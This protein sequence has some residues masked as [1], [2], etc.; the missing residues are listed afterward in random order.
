MS[1][2]NPPRLASW[3]LERFVSGPTRE[4]LI[5]DVAEQWRHGRS[6]GWY[7]RQVLTAIILSAAR[8]VW[9]HKLAAVRAVAICWVAISA[10]GIFTGALRESLFNN[11]LHTPW[12]S[13]IVRQAWVYYGLPFAIFTGIGFAVI[14][15]MISGL[16]RRH[17]AGMLLFCAMCQVLWS[18]PWGWETSRLLREGLWPFWDY[19]LALLFHGLLQFIGYPLCLLLGGASNRDEDALSLESR[20]SGR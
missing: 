4:S 12:R 15:W 1:T 18:V 10:M 9:A 8:D 2:P 17:R 7:W 6:A 11:W 20:R 5:G 13:E 19:R 14:G 3:L 16:H